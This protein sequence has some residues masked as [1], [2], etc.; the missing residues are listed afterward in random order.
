MAKAPVDL[1]PQLLGQKLGLGVNGLQRG[2]DGLA[3]VAQ[4]FQEGIAALFLF[5]RSLEAVSL[6]MVL[7]FPQVADQGFGLDRKSVV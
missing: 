6:G 2:E 3:D 1:Q 5:H 7:L 4:T